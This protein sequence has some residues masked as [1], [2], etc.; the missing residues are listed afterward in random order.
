M[1]EPDK[2]TPPKRLPRFRSYEEEAEFWDTHDS[3]EFEHLFKPTRLRF[4]EKIEHVLMVT[5]DGPVLDR[6]I[7]M[8]RSKDQGPVALAA[9]LIVEGLDRMGAPAVDRAAMKGKKHG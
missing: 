3:T 1:A 5:L 7:E 9:Q 8:A 4:A 2:K 6:L